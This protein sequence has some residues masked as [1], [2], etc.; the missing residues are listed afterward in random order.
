[1]KSIK[2]SFFTL[3]LTTLCFGQVVTPA[4]EEEY[5][6]EAVADQADGGSVSIDIT[7]KGADI[8]ECIKKAK[9]QA[10]FTTIFKGYPKTNNAS[11]SAALADMSLYAQNSEFFKGYLSST[12]GG[13]VF[14]NKAQTNMSKPSSKLDKKTIQSTTTVYLMKSKLR[15][16]LEKQGYIKSVG[17]LSESLGFMPTILVVPSDNWMTAKGFS[18][19]VET[20]LGS[21]KI[22]DYQSAISGSTMRIYNS[23]ENFLRNP[24]SKGFE[25]KSYTDIM[26]QIATA[27]AENM[28]RKVEESEFDLMARTA[29]AQ[30]WIKVDLVET[31]ISGGA[32]TQYTLSLTGVDPLLARSVIN[33]NPQTI[34]TSGDNYMRLLET[35]VNAAVDNFIPEVVNYFTKR[36]K[37]GVDGEIEFR[38]DEGSNVNFN[39]D[40]DGDVLAVWIDDFVAKNANVSNSMGAST[41]TLRA[42]K[43]TIPTKRTNK[44]TGKIQTNDMEQ[45]ARDV[46]RDLQP[47]GLTIEVRRLGLG[48]VV[49]YISK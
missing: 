21:Q 2:L 48:K 43:V 17:S 1:M 29:N 11:G 46:Q 41:A 6:F 27:K 26:T 8:A 28:Q 19:T 12:T 14:V 36:E 31:K 13:L 18:K 23:L 34:V 9:A 39:T 45:Y 22:Y 25:V 32:E 35:T 40:F 49:V 42:Y 33:G 20:D 3:F 5:Q 44:R 10:L 47:L 24:L 38:V 15:E 4:W 7:N 37:N 30:I 16:D